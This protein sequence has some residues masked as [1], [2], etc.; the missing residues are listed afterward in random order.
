MHEALIL[1]RLLM[2]ALL[3][4]IALKLV[5][6]TLGVNVFISFRMEVMKGSRGLF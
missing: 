4:S 1:N 3:F 6:K 2:V 5:T